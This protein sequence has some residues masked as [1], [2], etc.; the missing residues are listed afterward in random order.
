MSNISGGSTSYLQIAPSNI[1]STGRVSYSDGNPVL[2]FIIGETDRFL[3]G[4]SLRICG[5]LACY[6]SRAG[7]TGVVPLPAD[8]L[9]ISPK[10][11]AYSM[12]DQVVLSSQKTKNVIEHVRHYGRFLSS[13]LP[14]VSSQQEAIGHLS[15]SSGMFPNGLGERLS[16]VN[17]VNGSDGTDRQGA[18][19]SFCL[20]LPTGF[21]NNK[22]PI[23]L[24]SKGWG[25]GGLSIDIHLT[26]DSQFFN[27]AGTDVGAFYQ[28]TDLKLLCEVI[29]PSPDELSR[30]MRQ[31]STTMEYNAISSYYTT[32][33]STNAII[34]F[35]LGLSRVLGVF[36][37]FI[38][39]TY[40]NNLNF[41]GFQT[42]PLINNLAAGTIAP[43]KQVIWLKGGSQVPLEFN[44]D[45]NV[46]DY[47]ASVVAD[48]QLV[49]GI[50]NT[51]VP[52]MK[53][54]NS[55][56]T[57]NT[58]N[59]VSFTDYNNFV[60][61]GL[62]F[63]IGVQYDNISGDGLDFRTDNFGVQM[64]TGLTADNPHSAFIFVRSKQTLVMNANG[65]QVL[66]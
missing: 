23:G 13:Y 24:S 42:T 56:I 17:N 9:N 41:D 15:Q 57:P 18:G 54:K 60:D 21:L 12:I 61:A 29:N 4:S 51:F 3:I 50:M 55:Q 46:R 66:S 30:L 22:E 37:N 43:I 64:E 39:S 31:T 2:N 49:R 48:P 44:L 34:N 7:D 53:N 14:N 36:I 8:T 16:F 28:L 35:R 27:Q 26:P 58:F 40:L 63:G 59:R 10:L 65:L 25:V 6:K 45:A 5:N 52:F 1:V 20:N 38:P 47:P 19:N 33:N 62:C 32:V 11:G